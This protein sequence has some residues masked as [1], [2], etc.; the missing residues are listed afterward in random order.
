MKTTIQDTS[1]GNA[2]KAIRGLIVAYAQDQDLIGTILPFTKSNIR[3]GREEGCDLGGDDGRMSRH[4]ATVK[5]AQGA[6]E[7]SVSDEGSRNG[8]FVNGT[9]IV[10]AG[11]KIGDVLRCGGTF[12]VCDDIPT[13][14]VKPLGALITRAPAMAQVFNAIKQV[15]RESKI[16]VLIQGETGCGKELVAKELHR[17]SGR[18]NFVP[19]NCGAVTEELAESAFFGHVRGGFTGA[20]GNRRGYFELANYGTLFLDEL[21]EL[22]ASVQTALLRILEDGELTAV[23]AERP[24]RVDVR[25]VA[26]TNV[27]MMDAVAN[28]SFRSD[29]YARLNQWSITLPSLAQRRL[30]IPLLAEHF[31]AGQGSEEPEFSATAMEALLIYP[32][33]LNVRGL[34][35]EMARVHLKAQGSK[36]GL[37]HLSQEIQDHFNEQ[38]NR[39]SAQPSHEEV[40]E[41]TVIEKA[42]RSTRG[43]V[44]KACEITGIA[45]KTFYRR[46]EEYGITP[47]DFREG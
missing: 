37:E 8:T 22:P 29:L 35:N 40:D 26:A 34:K 32:W 10:E 47:S 13:K 7:G 42:L 19:V 28:D 43:N 36:I 11:L 15:A 6:Q 5:G 21:G 18:S 9:Q 38:R 45:R 17:Q 44:K 12:L 31:L 1:A 41:K 23:G 4:H 24:K 20:S 2:K 3:L 46:L 39:V 30:D 27:Q 14:A 33:P 16:S 25:V